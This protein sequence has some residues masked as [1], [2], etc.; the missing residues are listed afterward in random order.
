VH[1]LAASIRRI[2][3]AIYAFWYSVLNDTDKFCNKI[4]NTKITIENWR[5]FKE[6]HKNKD[7]ADALSLMEK[8]N[9]NWDIVIKESIHQADIG[10][11]LFP[12]FLF[13]F[14]YELKED[15]KADV[16]KKV[17]DEIRKISEDLLEKKLK[18]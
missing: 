10:A 9:V 8:F 18:K 7:K 15:L 4:K 6:V 13:D 16:P 12:V 1:T 17:L 14:L 11:Y 5:K 3:R 2:D